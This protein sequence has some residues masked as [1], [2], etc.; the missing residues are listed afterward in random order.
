M[1]TLKFPEFCWKFHALNEILELNAI[2]IAFLW[3]F[4]DTKYTDF[5]FRC[6][7]WA[8]VYVWERIVCMRYN[9]SLCQSV[10]VRIYFLRLLKFYDNFPHHLIFPYNKY[11]LARFELY[12]QHTED[13]KNNNTAKKN[14]SKLNWC[15]LAILWQYI[16][17]KKDREK[18]F[19]FRFNQKYQKCTKCARSD[20]MRRILCCHI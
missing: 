3:L 6:Y 18:G 13:N 8:S 14:E 9:F 15:D 16:N 5:A 4:K 12:R 17:E 2:F 1:E 7:I 19:F 10:N 20:C 11:E